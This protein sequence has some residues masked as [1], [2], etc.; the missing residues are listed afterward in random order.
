MGY[1]IDLKRT[2][3]GGIKPDGRQTDVAHMVSFAHDGLPFALFRGKGAISEPL[4]RNV[5][6]AEK[7]QFCEGSTSDECEARHFYG[8]WF[9]AQVCTEEPPQGC[10]GDSGGEECVESLM[11]CKPPH[12]YNTGSHRIAAV[13]W[14]R[15]ERF[16]VAFEEGGPEL[17]KVARLF[18]DN[19]EAVPK[20]VLLLDILVSFVNENFFVEP[21]TQGAKQLIEGPDFSAVELI[22]A[23]VQALTGHELYLSVHNFKVVE[24][25]FMSGAVIMHGCRPSEQMFRN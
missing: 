15:G 8:D 10:V 13:L 11:L 9:S 22:P 1:G 7:P 3:L 6:L 18:F 23:A 4:R 5:A 21:L 20:A 19:L 17:D 2:F 16:A 12:F 14:H 25:P 24:Y